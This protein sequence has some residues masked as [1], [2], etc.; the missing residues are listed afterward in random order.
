MNFKNREFSNLKILKE[1]GKYIAIVDRH[2]YAML[3]WTWASNIN[4][5]S[6]ELVSIDYHPDTNPPFYQKIMLKCINDNKEDDEEYF[7]YLLDLELKKVNR[8]DYKNLISKVDEL[9]NDEHINLAMRLDVLND[10]HMINCMDEHKYKTG[11]HYLLEGNH[12]GSLEND[13]FNSV[14]FSI[15]NKSYILDIDLDYFNRLD[16]FNIK[17]DSIFK[18]LVMGAD[19]ITVARSTKY[20]E[21]LKKQ[22]FSID[23]CEQTLMELI[24]SYLENN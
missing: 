13:M 17:D 12:F 18:S 10:Y 9:N 1:A 22:D 2:Q 15:P 4:Q 7:D 11:K 6:Y 20:F 3:I 14:G 19:I 23:E 5:N 8:Y 21:Y 24:K 16:N